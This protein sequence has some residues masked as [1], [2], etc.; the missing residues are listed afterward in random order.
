MKFYRTKY[1][2]ICKK[3]GK[4]IAT[5]EIGQYP[6]SWQFMFHEGCGGVAVP[7]LNHPHEE[8]FTDEREVKV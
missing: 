1:D 5:E 6:Y 3:C 4:T 8:V 7:D 2:I